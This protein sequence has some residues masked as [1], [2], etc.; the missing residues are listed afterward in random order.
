MTEG[1]PRRIAFLGFGLIAGS[2]ARAIATRVP[3]DVRPL[4]VA[5]S[6]SNAGPAAA[7]LDGV[8]DIAAGD[9]A[10]ALDGADL[11]V[12]AAP[13]L[14]TIQFLGALGDALGPSLAPDAVVTDVAST[15]ARVVDAADRAG[16]R[17]VGGHPMAGR[18]LSGYASSQ[19]DLFVDRPWVLVPGA[20]ADDTAIHRVAWLVGACGARPVVMDAAAH[21]RAAAAVSHL[22]LVLAAALVEA[23]AGGETEQPGWPVAASLAASGWRDMTRLARGDVRMGAGIAATNSAA[24]LPALRDLR[25]ALDGWIRDLERDGGPDAGSL[26]RR[27]RAVRE[28]LERTPWPGG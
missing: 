4:L 9:P 28:R 26:E 14:E 27:L 21:D 8:L 19:G 1:I 22:P 3:R 11:I 15:K 5:W 12:L 23:V 6:P 7:V 10:T 25:T 2:A 17:F 18:D 16:V 13:P 20:A 24:L